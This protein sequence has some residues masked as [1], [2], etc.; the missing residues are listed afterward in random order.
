M[1]I[2]EVG[3]DRV[4]IGDIGFSQE[5]NDAQ[6]HIELPEKLLD[7]DSYDVEFE[8]ENG[9]KSVLKNVEIRDN[10]VI[11]PLYQNVLEFGKLYFQIVA[12]NFDIDQKSKSNLYFGHVQRSINATETIEIVPEVVDQIY[13]EILTLKKEISSIDGMNE[14]EVYNLIKRYLKENPIEGILSEDERKDFIENTKA[15][16]NHLNKDVLDGITQEMLDKIGTDNIPV[17]HELPINAKEGDVCLHAL[18]N[19]LT[20]ADS[21][22]KIYIDWDEFRQPVNEEN[23]TEFGLIAYQSVSGDTLEFGCVRDQESCGLNFITQADYDNIYYQFS[24]SF[25]NGVIDVFE[26][27]TNVNGND[28]IIQI[29]SIEDLPKYLQLPQFDVIDS[30]D[31]YG[32]E[33]L[34]H[35]EYRLMKYQGGEWNEVK[36]KQ[37]TEEQLNNFFENTRLRHTHNNLDLLETIVPEML[38][39]EI[40]MVHTLPTES[41]TGDIC[42]YAPANKIMSEDSGKR[43]YFDWKNIEHFSLKKVTGSWV[44]Y[45]AFSLA[46]NVPVLLI[47]ITNHQNS[48]H[49]EIEACMDNQFIRKLNVHFNSD[50]QFNIGSFGMYHL[51]GDYISGGAYNNI[52]EL[53]SFWELPEWT[54]LRKNNYP[55]SCYF[56]HTGYKLMKYQGNEWVEAVDVPTKISQLENDSGF[57]TIED[58]SEASNEQIFSAVEDYFEENPI[59]IPTKVSEL[60]NDKDFATMYYVAEWG[61]AAQERLSLSEILPSNVGEGEMRIH[62]R[63]SNITSADIGKR[64]YF[65]WTKIKLGTPFQLFLYRN[66]IES[67]YA[68]SLSNIFQ[69]V[70]RDEN[71]NIIYSVVARFDEN[72]TL[73]EGFEKVDDV[74]KKLT[75]EELRSLVLTIPQFDQVHVVTPDDKSIMFHTECRL[76]KYQG[77]EW[78]EVINDSEFITKADIPIDRIESIE[79]VI[80][81]LP[82]TD[83]SFGECEALEITFAE[84]DSTKRN[85]YMFSFIS[86]ATPTALTLPSSVKW[87]NELTVEANKRYEVNIMDDIGL[88]CAV[89]YEVTE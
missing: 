7:F 46:V 53:P 88:W 59:K 62:A 25:V 40:P 56:F 49:Y 29:T 89:D 54:T 28:E 87:M 85:E 17:V 76:M 21:G 3:S 81:I 50:G 30:Y 44:I 33:Y 26:L 22:N 9:D 63:T 34:F 38:E 80:E 13:K 79:T 65:N 58:L 19:T 69:F 6:L 10:I 82:N 32:D 57:I 51:N 61:K 67:L 5:N 24:G 72:H 4:N 27:T 52:D 37:L 45:E 68:Q 36:Q 47:T 73:V 1:Q 35:T 77:G 14:E 42:R 20:L 18:Q 71:N 8:L 60:K 84:G 16:H 64:I 23:I 48:F 15:R 31:Q 55:S 83:Y 41:K 43:I 70:K 86:G 75:F 2:I 39:I 12:Y 11:V 78:V 66:N 74:R